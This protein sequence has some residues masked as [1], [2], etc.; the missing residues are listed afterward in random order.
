RRAESRTLIKRSRAVPSC[1]SVCAA[2]PGTRSRFTDAVSASCAAASLF[3]RWRCAPTASNTRPLAAISSAISPRRRNARSS[4]SRSSS[5]LEPPLRRFRLPHR[6]HH[7]TIAPS[8]RGRR[9]PY[10]AVG[11]GSRKLLISRGR[12]CVRAAHVEYNRALVTRRHATPGLAPAEVARL[13]RAHGRRAGDLSRGLFTPLSITW[14]VHREAAVLL[15]G[16]RA[17][18]LPVAH[19]PVPA[20]VAAPSPVPREPLTPLPPDLDL[21]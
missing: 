7:R 9:T 4:D 19:P 12:P 11:K 14:R 15:G 10:N 5:T 1:A 21:V 16:G 2:N 6:L 8:P 13:R 18:L 3:Q 17:L 20:G